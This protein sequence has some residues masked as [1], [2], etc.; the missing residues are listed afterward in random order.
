MK[1]KAAGCSCI[2]PGF[3]PR[4]YGTSGE[5][6]SDYLYHLCLFNEKY[7]AMWDKQ[8]KKTGKR[9]QPESININWEQTTELL[10]HEKVE[11]DKIKQE[12]VWDKLNLVG[13]F[14]CLI[15]ENNRT[16]GCK[17][18]KRGD[19]LWKGSIEGEN[20]VFNRDDNEMVV[21]VYNTIY[22]GELRDY[23][24]SWIYQEGKKAILITE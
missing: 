18:K 4:H 21:S 13:E 3:C 17:L 1:K 5:N 15:V 2:F 11:L 23:P 20:I 22:G 7:R 6:K 12:R 8:A 10:E 16:S 14:W 19:F 24:I 9:P